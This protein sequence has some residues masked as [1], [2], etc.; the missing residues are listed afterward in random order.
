MKVDLH[1]ISGEITGKIELPDEIFAAKINTVLMAQA[2]RVYLA[3]Q[4]QGTQSA[5]T[6]GEVSGSGRKIYRQKGT[7]HAR[8]GDNYAPIFVGGGIAFPPKP[9]NFSLKMG[10]KAKK[11][12]LFSA[13]SQKIK[14]KAII[15]VDG[16]EQI[17]AKTKEMVKTLSVLSGPSNLGHQKILLVLPGNLENL[18][19]AA[20][21]IEGI[22]LV[23][24]GLLNPYPVL[25]SDKIIFLKDS[26]KKLTEVFLK[27]EQDKKMGIENQILPK[28]AIS[29]EKKIVVKKR[30]RPRRQVRQ[31]MDDNL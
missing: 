4:R 10:K 30:G 13:L 5:K 31:Q 16:L 14:E 24:A 22:K 28:E 29:K 2:V 27:K 11:K 3:N 8:H 20:R 25:E 17:R 12:A 18:I 1:N 19:L 9:R 15:I 23:P 21:N 6:R 7:G 26:I